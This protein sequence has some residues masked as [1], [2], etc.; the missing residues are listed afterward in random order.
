MVSQL[1]RTYASLADKRVDQRI[2]TEST[3]SVTGWANRTGVM[4][5]NNPD[6]RDM[7]KQRSRHTLRPHHL[8]IAVYGY[9]NIFN[10]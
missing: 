4:L 7:G 9:Y 2:E 6:Y 10:K 8:L 3:E 5:F 1:A